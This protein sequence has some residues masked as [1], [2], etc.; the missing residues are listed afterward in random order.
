MTQDNIEKIW[1]DYQSEFSFLK[2][3]EIDRCVV[4]PNS[5]EIQIHGF[6]DASEAA[7]GAVIYIRSKDVNS[8]CMVSLL[9]AKSRVS[10]LKQETLP[11]LELLAAHLLSELYV[12]VKKSLRLEIV[13]SY[14]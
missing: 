1:K 7:Y 6:A 8:N 3:L 4:I 13:K 10:P 14:L 12:K 2:N 5:T 11:W 9:C